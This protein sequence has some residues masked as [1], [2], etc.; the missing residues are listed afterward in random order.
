MHRK[1]FN[2]SLIF[3]FCT[4]GSAASEPLM[5]LHG[6]N[7]TAWYT[8]PRFDSFERPGVYWPP[9]PPNRHMP[10]QKDFEEIHNLGF[11]AIRIG[12]EPALFIGLEGAR[13]DLVERQILASVEAARNVGLVVIFDLHPNS[14]HKIY[15]QSALSAMDDG[16]AELNFLL[17]VKRASQLLVTLPSDKVI[18]EIMNEPRIKCSGDEET[19]W[20]NFLD[21]AITEIHSEAPQLPMM[22]SGACAS[23]VDGLMSLDPA[24]WKSANLYFTFHFYD[25]FPFTHQSA[26]FTP[27]PEKYLTNLPWPPRGGADI[28]QL[29]SAA[30][31]RIAALAPTDPVKSRENAHAVLQ[32]Y[33][34]SGASAATLAQRLQLAADW[35][36]RNRIPRDHI[37]MGEFGV[38]HDS[39]KGIGATCEDRAAWVNDV[40]AEAERLGFSWS[41]FH[42]DGP[43]GIFSA[44]TGKPD[45][46]LLRALGFQSSGAC[47]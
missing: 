39:E 18:L 34:S 15:G 8:W 14:K 16:S 30:E 42:L 20:E 11:N 7:A 47:Q 5:P 31:D 6:I 25:P 37:F 1:A 12:V 36:D 41:Y 32:K 13:L 28:S 3:F 17:A 22:I 26:P 9:F 38:Y 23:S 44:K 2:L 19:R 4:L 21:K 10:E 35:A 29:E 24:R 33:L 43:F 27:W 46:A 45:G 40:R